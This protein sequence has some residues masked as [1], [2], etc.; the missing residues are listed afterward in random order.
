[1]DYQNFEVTVQQVP[2]LT[3]EIVEK[4]ELIFRQ[5]I[6]PELQKIL[7]DIT[8]DES[9]Y[10][11]EAKSTPH[12]LFSHLQEINAKVEAGTMC[13]APLAFYLA[14]FFKDKI[15]QYDKMSADGKITFDH[16]SKLFTIGTEFAATN[17]GELVGSVV[18]GCRVQPGMFGEKYFIITG[19]FITSNGKDFVHS[20]KDFSVSQFRGLQKVEDLSV[21]PM[22]EEDRKI[23]T[24]RGK[25]FKK[26]GLG[27]HYVKYD[28]NMFRNTPYGPQY[29]K[30]DGRAMTDVIGFNSVNPNYGTQRSGGNNAQAVCNED[31][32][33]D[34]LY[35]TWPFFQGF[36][37]TAKQ[38]GE[39]YV[40]NMSD[41]KF[42]SDAFDYLVLDET[43]KELAK[44]LITN[45]DIGFTDII[46]GKS[47]GCIFLLH[48]PPGTGKTLTC[49]AIAEL[50]QK[51]LYSITVGE[52]GTTP[53]QL[54]GR[55]SKILDIANSWNSV[56]LIDE[57]DVFLEK[58]A[59]ND[60]QR[61]ALVSIFL[62]LLERHQGVM[63]LT[64]NRLNSIDEAF[65]SRTSVVIEYKPLDKVTRIQIW[66]NL[67][68][69]ANVV[70]EDD[71]LNVLAD[72]NINGRQIKNAI[73]MA[74]C[75]AHSRKE[76]IALE[77]FQTVISL[78]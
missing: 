10:N 53:D 74:Q 11:K 75:L 15:E 57:A 42:D 36:S 29:F 63:F 7:V 37:F 52:L 68:R 32:P 23:L 20:Q 47:G 43:K 35:M 39:M 64:T 54:E 34:L 41:I 25:I 27:A 55:L 66:I 18:H 70:V 73:R 12:E 78:M 51:P 22:T 5:D 6:D 38:W 40:K 28:G 33:E 48:G 62:R 17:N 19:M 71:V 14:D 67:L 69:A 76:Q 21:R 60:I 9:F 13:L 49:E 31:I 61:N 72:N 16:L 46:S 8:D 2:T 3:G 58:R 77:H 50:L 45:T 26:F 24:E 1:M 30:A 65:R 44:A 56:I 4:T 59:E